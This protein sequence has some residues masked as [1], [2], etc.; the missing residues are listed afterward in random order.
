MWKNPNTILGVY[1]PLLVDLLTE[2]GYPLKA[3]PDP[4]FETNPSAHAL[5]R[6]ILNRLQDGWQDQETNNR[7]VR[8][9]LLAL[10]NEIEARREW[11]LVPGIWRVIDD[12]AGLLNQS[13][14]AILGYIARSVHFL[15]GSERQHLVGTRNNQPAW[16][17]FDARKW[18][19][20]ELVL[21]AFPIDS[22]VEYLDGNDLDIIPD[23]HQWM[24]ESDLP[25]FPVI[26]NP[27]RE[28]GILLEDAY[29]NQ[30]YLPNAAG[31]YVRLRGL[32]GL[33][34]V[35]I[36]TKRSLLDPGYIDFLACFE[37]GQKKVLSIF[38]GIMVNAWRDL[39]EDWRDTRYGDPS[40][41]EFLFWLTA[42]IYHD[43]VTAK[44]IGSRRF[45]TAKEVDEG[46][47]VRSG[48]PTSCVA[49]TYIP[50]V[51]RGKEQEVRR[52]ASSKRSPTPHRVSGHKRKGNLTEGH[53][54]ALK[55]FEDETGFEILR[56]L[57]E[58]YTF[59]RP[60]ISPAE[61]AEVI[62]ELPRFIRRRIQEDIRKLLVE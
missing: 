4:P 33:D 61:G 49:W 8:R 17:A 24:V 16:K 5:V 59:V 23:D 25:N 7:L 21:K 10:A 58:G 12:Y 26:K 32:P 20:I 53:K 1:A 15:V 34:G 44:D 45:R 48:D 2:A 3:V 41:R 18:N 50:R 54:V 22:D 29:Y 62:Q 27:W 19:G 47:G 9:E 42:Q 31:S 13:L 6:Q 39:G 51:V 36:K 14:Y 43:L 56:W 40:K 60:H 52:P 55:S 30:Q 57:P 46:L 28:L 35:V 38:S 37:C 11:Q